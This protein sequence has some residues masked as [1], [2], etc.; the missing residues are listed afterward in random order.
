MRT[1]WAHFEGP[2]RC[3]ALLG[4]GCDRLLFSIASR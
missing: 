4:F 1:Y 3:V 2:H